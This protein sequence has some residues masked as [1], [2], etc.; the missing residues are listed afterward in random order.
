MHKLYLVVEAV[1]VDASRVYR[2]LG[3]MVGGDVRQ[4][5]QMREGAAEVVG[6]YW[7]SA[8]FEFLLE[9]DPNELEAYLRRIRLGVMD[10]KAD[11]VLVRAV[12]IL[13]AQ[14]GETQGCDLP[15]NVLG[16]LFEICD[17]LDICIERF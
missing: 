12:L 2:A 16:I 15:K 10:N 1:G 5:K 13:G 6:Q 14:Y 8:P 7:N 3:E 4:R 17:H 11:G 9:D